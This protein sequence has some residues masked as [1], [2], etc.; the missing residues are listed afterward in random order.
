MSNWTDHPREDL[1]M[2][3]EMQAHG[4][5][6]QFDSKDTMYHRTKPYSVP[7]DSVSFVKGTIHVW[8]TGKGWQ[9]AEL[10]DGCYSNHRGAISAL[11]EPFKGDRYFRGFIPDL[12]T[13]LEL[14]AKNDL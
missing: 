12:K 8:S 2:I 5:R 13:V 4:W 9:V 10:I 14:D 1:R 3:P 6:P 7:H 11:S